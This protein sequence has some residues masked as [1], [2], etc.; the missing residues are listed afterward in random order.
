MKL[1]SLSLALALCA[2][3]PALAQQSTRVTILNGSTLVSTSNPLPVSAVI[4]PA[5]TQD[6]NLTKVGGTAF[7]LGQGL[8]AASLPVTIASNQSAILATL[9][10][11][12]TLGGLAPTPSTTSAVVSCTVLKA[13]AGQLY[14]L[15]VAIGA[16][17]GYVMIFNA[18][19]AP[20]DGAVTPAWTPIRVVSDG[21]SGWASYSWGNTPL[22]L[23]TGITVC[24]SSTGP[25][26]KTASSTA[27]ITGQIN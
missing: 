24:F 19:S 4:T 13:S 14:S 16:T 5:G 12:A 11:S 6:V 22:T 8:M 21:T 18:T 15:N 2:G 20:I 27:V 25:F 17:T 3:T 23:G 26:T 10:P 7:A 9:T 1:I